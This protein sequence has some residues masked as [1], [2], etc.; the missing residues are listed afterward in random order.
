MTDVLGVHF[1]LGHSVFNMFLLILYLLVSLAWWDP[2]SWPG[3]PG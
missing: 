2:V 1:L 3:Q